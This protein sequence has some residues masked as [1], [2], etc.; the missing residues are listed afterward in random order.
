ME[1][2]LIW[3]SIISACMCLTVC[4]HEL[5]G[6]MR[7]PG[8]ITRASVASILDNIFCKQFLV[9]KRNEKRVQ[10]LV[11]RGYTPKK[12]DNRV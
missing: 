8:Q 2:K 7:I 3:T 12:A 11:A 5:R 6:E 9:V 4:C 1:V 10:R